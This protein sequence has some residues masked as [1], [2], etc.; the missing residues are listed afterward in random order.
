VARWEKELL[1]FASKLTDQYG[2]AFEEMIN[3]RVSA[4]DSDAMSQNIEQN[5]GSDLQ[6]IRINGSIIGGLIG[7]VLHAVGLYLWP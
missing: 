1:K 6:Y 4:W 3:R 5:I 2:A 7:L